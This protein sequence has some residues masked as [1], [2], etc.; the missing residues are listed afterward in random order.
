MQSATA[1]TK[2]RV[3]A[4]GA[5]HNLITFLVLVLCSRTVVGTSTLFLLG[6]VDVSPLGVAVVS[7]EAV[8]FQQNLLMIGIDRE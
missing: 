8:S 6:Y 4:A 5:Y 2:L 3:I 1:Q 7:L